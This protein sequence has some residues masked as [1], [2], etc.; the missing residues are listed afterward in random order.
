[1]HAKPPLNVPD[2]IWPALACRRG[3]QLA[4][5]SLELNQSSDSG[6]VNYSCLQD[7]TMTVDFTEAAGAG[8]MAGWKTAAY[9]PIFHLEPLE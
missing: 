1:M 9:A 4:L 5:A 2:P 7:I 8:S 3:S 6:R